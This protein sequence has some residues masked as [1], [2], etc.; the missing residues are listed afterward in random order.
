MFLR[1]RI[2][3]TPINQ[4]KELV[5]WHLERV[6]RMLFFKLSLIITKGFLP[7]KENIIPVVSY[8][9]KI[10]CVCTFWFGRNA[11]WLKQIK[12]DKMGFKQLEIT[13]AR[14]IYFTLDRTI[15]PKCITT[16]GIF[17]L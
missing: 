17:N 15:G 13:S 2:I 9:I 14:I 4:T 1:K 3:D 7:L 5:G 10:V 16:I 12:L 11:D 8:A 6:D